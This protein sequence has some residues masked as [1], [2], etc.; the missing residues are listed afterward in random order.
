MKKRIYLVLILMSIISFTVQSCKKEAKAEDVE[1]EE[2]DK[3]TNEITDDTQNE[4]TN[5]EIDRTA[6][7][8]TDDT[9]N[10]QTDK[11]AEEETTTDNT[12]E[13]KAYICSKG[14]EKGKT[15]SEE[16]YCPVCKE[17]LVE[18]EAK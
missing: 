8:V 1:T 14:C 16:G 3:V 6:D 17:K 5:Q 12:Q 11:E 15:Y 2:I 9:Q 18:N 4:Q 10:E 13:E 7:Q